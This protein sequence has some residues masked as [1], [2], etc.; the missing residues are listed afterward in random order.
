MAHKSRNVNKKK[1]AQIHVCKRYPAIH[2]ITGSSSA[3][4]TYYDAILQH[5]AQRHED[6][7]KQNHGQT[8]HPVHLPLAG[9]YGDDDKEEHDEEQRDGT[10]KS[11]AADGYWSQT[12][13]ERVKEPWGWT[14]MKGTNTVSLSVNQNLFFHQAIRLTPQ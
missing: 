14:T 3:H 11:T 8:K 5:N 4:R 7:V 6:E 10:Q 9:Y 13:D 12:V 2:S 1:K